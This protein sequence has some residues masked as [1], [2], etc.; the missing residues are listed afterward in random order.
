MS[1]AQTNG[2]GTA[3]PDGDKGLSPKT[4]YIVVGVVAAVVSA[5]TVA[6][7]FWRRTRDLT[8]KVESVQKL[9]D[10]SHDMMRDLH[11]KLDQM[12]ASA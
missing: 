7:F 1:D 12:T 10:K 8:P 5:A 6:F 3:E 9:L 11:R 2:Q 4:T